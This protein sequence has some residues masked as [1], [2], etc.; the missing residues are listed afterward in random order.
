MTERLTRYGRAAGPP[1]AVVAACG[2][3]TTVAVAAFDLP[4]WYVPAVVAVS[5]VLGL[6]AAVGLLLGAVLYRRSF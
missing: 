2:L 3:A 4:A 5:A 1:L 6:L